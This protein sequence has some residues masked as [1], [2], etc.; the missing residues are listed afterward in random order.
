MTASNRSIE[1]DVLSVGFARRL[2]AGH[3]RHWV[4]EGLT[5]EMRDT[6]VPI[7]DTLWMR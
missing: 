5:W 2:V 6:N 1:T 7:V 3:L 4:K